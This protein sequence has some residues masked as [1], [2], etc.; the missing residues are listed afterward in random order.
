MSVIVN[1]PSA[2]HIYLYLSYQVLGA[3][4]L[5]VGRV[6]SISTTLYV[7]VP[8]PGSS[9]VPTARLRV[10]AAT[11]MMLAFPVQVSYHPT[12]W[13]A[14][15]WGVIYCFLV[16]AVC[17]EGELRLVDGGIPSRGR[18]E[19]CYQGV[20]GT[21]CDDQWDDTDAGVV[22]AQLGF[23]RHSKTWQS[24]CKWLVNNCA[25]QSVQMPLHMGVP[26]TVLELGP[27]NLTMLL[28]MGPSWGCW[29]AEDTLVVITV[30]TQRMLLLL[31]MSQVSVACY[32]EI[33]QGQ[34]EREHVTS[35]S[36]EV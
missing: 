24:H 12:Q 11:S 19:V 20:W 2:H 34:R 31:A 7:W 9:T 6:P 5:E 16:V 30:F 13:T 28:V 10:T 3:P 1:M 22:C 17:S 33:H 25:L 32:V 27:F 18:V 14:T 15:V 29:T 26:G 4:F 36:S 21:V 23:S 35:T 8:K